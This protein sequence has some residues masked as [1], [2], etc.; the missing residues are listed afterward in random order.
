MIP[1]VMRTTEEMIKLVPHTLRE[2]ALAL[3]YARWRTSLSIVVRTCLPGIVTGGLL[4]IARVAGET[5]PLL[6]TALGSQFMSRD[7]N[8]PMAALP[9]TVYTYATGPYDDWHRIAW[10][11]A[12]VLIMVV[13]TLSLLARLA[14]RQRFD[15]RQ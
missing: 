7:L 5:A 1:M 9:L 10:A 4:A 6:F 14:T 2:A 8:Q 15:V 13:L 12:L 11:T 3:G